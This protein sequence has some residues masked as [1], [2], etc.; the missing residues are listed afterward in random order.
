MIEF[1]M[2][3]LG[4]DMEDGTL[5]EWKKKPGDVVKRGDI[6]AEVE[7]QKGLIEIEV[8][9]EGSIAELLIQEGTKVPVGT[10]MALIQPNAAEAEKPIELHPIM[11]KISVPIIDTWKTT[12]LLMACHTQL[13]HFKAMPA[14]LRQEFLW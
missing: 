2:P 7:T 1:Q 5:I 8:F 10:K 6:I 9:D 14:K 11:E 12:K 4:A 13:F 3:S